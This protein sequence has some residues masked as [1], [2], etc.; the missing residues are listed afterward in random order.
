MAGGAG[1]GE[2]EGES[3]GE[4]AWMAGF[5]VGGIVLVVVCFCGCGFV[6]RFWFQWE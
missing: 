6:A 5:G 1:G 3:V 2:R 4:F